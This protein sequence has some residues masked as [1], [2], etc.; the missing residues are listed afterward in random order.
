MIPLVLLRPSASIATPG[1]PE[2]FIP[3]MPSDLVLLC[4]ADYTQSGATILFPNEGFVLALSPAEQ[5]YLRSYAQDKPILKELTVKN[6]TYEVIDAPSSSSSPTPP[7]QQAYASTA[8]R[9]FNSKINVSNVQ[10]RILATLLSGLT[11]KDL[12][13]MTTNDSVLFM[14]RDITPQWLHSFENKNSRTPDILQLAFHPRPRWKQERILSSQ[15]ATY[16]LR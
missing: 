7:L 1:P 3:N 16:S 4:A 15:K 6:N 2:L 13:I 11:F 10:E 12:L 5:Q 9:Y 14:P 8:T